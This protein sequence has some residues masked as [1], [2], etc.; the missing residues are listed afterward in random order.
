MIQF[1]SC[2]EKNKWDQDQQ[3]GGNENRKNQGNELKWKDKKD[4]KRGEK[5]DINI[6]GKEQSTEKWR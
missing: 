1:V 2:I 5:D 4:R 3:R 6:L